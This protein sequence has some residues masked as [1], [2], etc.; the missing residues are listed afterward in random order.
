MILNHDLAKY[1][2]QRSFRL[3]VIVPRHTDT[4]THMYMQP[5]DCAP[6]PLKWSVKNR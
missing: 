1:L 3:K 4:H 6:Q 2:R 5:T